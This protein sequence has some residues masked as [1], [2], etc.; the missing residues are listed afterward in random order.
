MKLH[1]LPIYA[2]LIFASPLQ[3]A[4]YKCVVKGQTVFSDKVCS[5]EAEEVKLNI[6]KPSPV[7]PLND[8]LIALEENIKSDENR[9]AELQDQNQVI[10]SEISEIEKELAESAFDSSSDLSQSTESFTENTERL[11]ELKTQSESIEAEISQLQQTISSNK[12]ESTMQSEQAIQSS[13]L[14]QGAEEVT[15]G[16]ATGN[17]SQ[18][19]QSVSTTQST[20]VIPVTVE[21]VAVEPL[22]P[23]VVNSELTRI[24]QL[25]DKNNYLESNIYQL[26]NQ[27]QAI[28][29]DGQQVTEDIKSM[30]TLINQIGIEIQQNQGIIS[31]FDK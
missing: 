20:D 28:S 2:S 15:G 12:A 13:Q 10:K 4:V 30:E 19:E 31:E 9:L 17:V 21:K 24:E 1:Y 18:V 3:A 7:I 8:N 26:N 29:S 16:N 14:E 22:Q 5:T 27:Y 23:Y 6:S 11:A 25:K